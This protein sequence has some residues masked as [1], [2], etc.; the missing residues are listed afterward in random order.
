MK[1][2]LLFIALFAVLGVASAQDS[3]AI[4][5]NLSIVEYSASAPTTGWEI[6]QEHS[7]LVVSTYVERTHIGPKGGTAVGVEFRNLM[8]VGV[9]YQ[10]SDLILT[11]LGKEG[12]TDMPLLY[13]KQF[14]GIYY[15]LPIHHQGMV[16]FDF[17]IRTGVSNGENFVITPS[18]HSSLKLT[19]S[20]ELQ[21]GVGMRAF[22][23]TVMTSVNIKL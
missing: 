3:L 8:S 19:R 13:E 11:V 2:N 21:G 16:G 12:S 6:H 14:Y 7:R 9:F 18:A 1:K 4:Q 23:P 17:K 22:R 5:G 20:I 10:E 15:T